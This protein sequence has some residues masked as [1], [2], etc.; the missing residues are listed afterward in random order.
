MG[1]MYHVYDNGLLI[2]GFPLLPTAVNFIEEWRHDGK[3]VDL[4]D[5]ETGEVI[6]T[7]E[8]GKW[9]NGNY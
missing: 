6:D 1:I 8:K 9:E 5:A 2:A 4:V 7:Y 3:P